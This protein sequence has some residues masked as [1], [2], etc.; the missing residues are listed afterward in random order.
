MHA[1]GE[2]GHPLR[3]GLLAVVRGGLDG[4]VRLFYRTI[5]LSG[6]EH[7][8][9]RGPV[10]VVANHPNGLA[11]PVV[12]R[13]ALGRAIA[14][15]AKST[16]FEHG[17]A[18]LAMEAFGAIPI[19]R[20]RDGRPTADNDETFAR[21]RRRLAEGG[22]VALFP[23]GTTHSEPGLKPLKTGAARIALGAL[24]EHTS[25]LTVLPVG[26][27]YEDKER[28]R[29][30]VAVSVGTPLDL[31]R[32]LADYAREPRGAV[33]R[34]TAEIEAALRRV[35]LEAETRE[36]AA[37]PRPGAV[38]GSLLF[39]LPVAVVGIVLGWLPYRL[40]RPL[41]LAFLRDSPEL[42]GT[43]KG[44]LGVVIMTLAYLAEA[45]AAGV[46]LGAWAALAV[47]IG[48]PVSGLVAV[49]FGDGLALR[50]HPSSQP[51]R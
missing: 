40:V 16:F 34:V 48:G 10:L 6:R 19:H 15:L 17:I 45:I 28:F 8:P 27:L 51:G 1:G 3:A 21:C 9:A 49:R 38:V 30:G 12:L 35:T 25:G 43:T 26:L 7:V 20:P 41:T 47:L 44:L 5:A 31:T 33:E 4:L 36:P 29:S 42:V 46:Y 11:D 24:A 14:F 22:W 32:H 39:F 23:E 37:E 18:R 13:L 50:R 2:R